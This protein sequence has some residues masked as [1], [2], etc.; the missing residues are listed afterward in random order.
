MVVESQIV[1]WYMWY[2]G[3]SFRINCWSHVDTSQIKTWIVHK[4]LKWNL[5][6]SSSTMTICNVNSY[7]DL[8]L[9][10]PPSFSSLSLFLSPSPPPPLSPFPHYYN[11]CHVNYLFPGLLLWQRVCLSVCA[12]ANDLQSP[13]TCPVRVIMCMSVY[14]SACLYTV[15]HVC[16]P[17]SSIKLL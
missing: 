12:A 10:L 14:Y 1:R 16:K 9:P 2:W 3:G 5:S 17:K 13:Y 6:E 7:D 11:Q 8:F 15:V 4:T